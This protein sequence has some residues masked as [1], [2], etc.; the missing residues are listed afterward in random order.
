MRVYQEALLAVGRGEVCATDDETFNVTSNYFDD[1]T[2]LLLDFCS[3]KSNKDACGY[4]N[5]S[6]AINATTNAIN[7]TINQTSL[8]YGNMCYYRV[9][10]GCGYPSL[11][12]NGKN[13]DVLIAYNDDLWDDDNDDDDDDNDMDDD[14]WNGTLS[15]NTT[16]KEHDDIDFDDFDNLEW[17][18]NH[19]A[20]NDYW[21]ATLNRTV[22]LNTVVYVSL[23]NLDK[24]TNT[25]PVFL[26]ARQLAASQNVTVTFSTSKEGAGNSAFT[27]VVS[28]FGLLVAAL[29]TLAF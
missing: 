16:F 15:H 14:H 23:I 9:Q 29:A 5:G 18:M 8:G 12:I 22:C 2:T 26:E 11:N 4:V 3:W 24:P 10:T 21:N 20:K 13:L 28:V 25:T 1:D 6:N 19:N 17:T 7:I 27:K